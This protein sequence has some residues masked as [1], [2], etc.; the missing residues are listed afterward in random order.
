MVKPDTLPYPGSAGGPKAKTRAPGMAKNFLF[1]SAAMALAWRDGSFRSFQSSRPMNISAAFGTLRLFRMFKPL[2]A[3]A[4]RTPS[5]S[6]T[7][8]ST[9]LRISSDLCSE[10]PSGSS[11]ATNR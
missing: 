7:I 10:A 3:S 8:S 4:E 9:C 2:R 1:H 11:I 5:V 6:F